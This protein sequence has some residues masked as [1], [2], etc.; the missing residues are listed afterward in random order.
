MTESHPTND[1]LRDFDAGRL[2][3][4]TLEA[5]A[6]HLEDCRECRNL[7]DEFE[8]DAEPPSLLR[9]LVPPGEPDDD[10]ACREMLDRARARAAFLEEAGTDPGSLAD[11]PTR[12]MPTPGAGPTADAQPSSVNAG[13]SIPPFGD[14]EYLVEV[15]R[16]GNGIVYRAWNRKLRRYEAVKIPAH[17]AAADANARDRFTFEATA[18]AGLEHPNI[19]TVYGVGD[20]DGRPYLSMKWIDGASLEDVAGGYEDRPRETAALVARIARAVHF[21]HQR[22]ILHRDVKTGNVMLDSSGEPHVCDFGLARPLDAETT[23]TVAG[24]L[25]YMPP[26]QARGQRLS[27]RADVYAIGAVL[28]RLVTGR[29][30]FD[31]ESVP[32]IHEQLVDGVLPHV[33][34]LPAD[35]DPDLAAICTKCLAASPED[36]YDD[37]EA[38]AADLEA[39]LEGR[40]IV[41]RPP[42]LFD[43]VRQS[44]RTRPE[45][46]YRFQ[47]PVLVWFGAIALVE[48]TVIY[49]LAEVGAAAAYVQLANVLAA[50]GIWI[51]IWWYML[52]RFR[53]LPTSERHSLMVAIAHSLAG[54]FIFIAYAPLSWTIPASETL[55]LYPALLAITGMGLFV[56]GSTHWSR[57]FLVGSLVL[58]QIPFA[59]RF[60]ELGPLLCGAAMAAALWYWAAALVARQR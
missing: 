44:L 4:E 5:V 11:E 38:L 22:G 51:V 39:W 20:I 57:F 15:A 46:G 16:G 29:R 40:A 6:D 45:E 10:A 55:D 19:V 35:L 12:S 17:W 43:W 13:S 58:L 47:W 37:A 26:E 25:P 23:G 33:A 1:Q 49:A 41:A 14:Y 3:E 52:H 42:G 48:H 36:R 30:P 2:D 24:T 54:A 56:I 59:V 21:A 32:R 31:G 9:G 53:E 27:V 28:Y 60:R 50:I 34:N 8:R 7:V 18:T